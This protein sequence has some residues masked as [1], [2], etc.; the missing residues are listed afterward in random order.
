MM[1]KKL[2]GKKMN[3]MLAQSEAKIATRQKMKNAKTTTAGRMYP[4]AGCVFA[5]SRESSRARLVSP[6]DI[7]K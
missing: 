3:M 1:P 5:P 2:D 4:T 7:T 6:K